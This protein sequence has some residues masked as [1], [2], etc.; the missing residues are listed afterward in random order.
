MSKHKHSQTVDKDFGTLAEDARALTVA[1]VD[2]ASER[3][4]EARERLC[5]ALENVKSKTIQ[6]AKAIDGR[7][8][9]HPYQAIA[10]GAGVG[11]VVGYL[12]ARR[13]GGAPD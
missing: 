3:V 8:R 7:V 4:R 5:T 13:S 1:T 2:V 9:Q 12:F 6:R 11:A 10:I